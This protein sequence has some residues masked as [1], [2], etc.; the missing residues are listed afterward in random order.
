MQAKWTHSAKTEVFVDTK[1]IPII[2][3]QV[4]PISQQEAFE[5]RNLWK[6]VT[7]ALLQQDV[8]AATSAKFTIEQKQRELVK[9]RQEKGIKWENRVLTVHIFANQLNSFL[10]LCFRSSIH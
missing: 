10:K 9:Q 5:S 8:N 6:E 3:K 7:A 4:N 1:T 2:K